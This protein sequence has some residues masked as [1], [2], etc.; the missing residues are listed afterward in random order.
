ML[1]P[2]VGCIFQYLKIKKYE[3]TT[4]NKKKNLWALLLRY[5]IQ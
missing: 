2:K 4:N 5:V 3:E 1:L